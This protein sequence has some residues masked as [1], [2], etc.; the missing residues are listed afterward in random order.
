MAYA[1]VKCKSQVILKMLLWGLLAWDIV[2][3]KLNKSPGF[4]IACFLINHPLGRTSALGEYYFSV[5]CG[6]VIWV[7]LLHSQK[8]ADCSWRVKAMEER[9]NVHI[10]PLSLFR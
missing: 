5:Q 6:A 4:K 8:Q 7:V 3:A 1:H 2:K 10:S 9:A